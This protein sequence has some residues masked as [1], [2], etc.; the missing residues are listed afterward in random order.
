MASLP[1]RST[2][3]GK[4]SWQRALNAKNKIIFID[5][6]LKPSNLITPEYI[7]WNQ[8]KDMVVT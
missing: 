3:N 1:T 2:Q 6:T 5:D 7:Q 4:K 8:I